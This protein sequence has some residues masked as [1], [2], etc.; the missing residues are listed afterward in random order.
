MARATVRAW[1]QAI[2]PGESAAMMA[3]TREAVAVL[4][5]LAQRVRIGG[6]EIDPDGPSVPIGSS[7]VHV[8]DVVA[9]RRNERTLFTDRGRIVKNRDRWTVEAVHRD[10]GLV[11]AG[12]SGQVI[13][14]AE[15]VSTDVELAY[16]ETSH[17]TQGRTVDRS[18]LYLDGPTGTAGIYVP[19]TR[20][21]STNEAFVVLHD[22]GTAAEVI[23][24]AVARTWIDQP[25][26]AV[27][28]DQGTDLGGSEAEGSNKAPPLDASREAEVAAL[29]RRL[30]ALQNRGRGAPGLGL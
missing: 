16:A 3:P 4:N 21:R 23:A 13:L 29:G 5:D 20:G 19:L 10:G 28:L 30:D 17:A 9:T 24:D 15:Y 1:R 8:G 27:R 7:R 6:G 26:T 18:F 11:V 2:E 22:E 14:P 12:Q 25:A